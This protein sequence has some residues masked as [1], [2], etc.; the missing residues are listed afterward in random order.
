MQNHSLMWSFFNIPKIYSYS[1][2]SI[3]SEFANQ[4]E[5]I[6]E[7]RF[8][9]GTYL[10]TESLYLLFQ[11]I[12]ETAWTMMSHRNFQKVSL[13]G[14]AQ[15]LKSDSLHTDHNGAADRGNIDLF[16]NLSLSDKLFL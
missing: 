5:N 14:S 12:F 2:C 8:L 4:R 13:D 16:N 7:F 11:D 9:C 1:Y 3:K 6:K 15:E 10:H